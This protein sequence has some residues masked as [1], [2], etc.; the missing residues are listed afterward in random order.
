MRSSRRQR[1]RKI[2]TSFAV[3]IHS[4]RQWFVLIVHQALSCDPKWAST[5]SGFGLVL[6][7]GLA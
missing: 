3:R 7:S 4:D 1:V 5:V 2:H 6:Y